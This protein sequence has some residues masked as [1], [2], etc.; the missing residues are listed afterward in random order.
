MIN[1]LVV[2]WHLAMLLVN[3]ELSTNETD[4]V[5]STLYILLKD[6]SVFVKSWAISGLTILALKK[7]NKKEDRTEEI[8][9]LQDNKSP[10]VEIGFQRL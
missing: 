10:A 6:K 4:K 2:R 8:K 3:L 5:I 1:C 7:N 9:F